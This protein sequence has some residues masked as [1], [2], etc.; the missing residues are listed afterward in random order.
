VLVMARRLDNHVIDI[1]FFAVAHQM[2]KDFVHQSLVGRSGVLKA[3]R[4]NFVKIISVVSGKGGFVHVGCGHGDLIVTRVC[5]QNMRTL[6]PVA[7]STSRSML[8]KG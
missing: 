2:T 3:E 6:F 4:H 1:Y 5:V 7:P 8:G